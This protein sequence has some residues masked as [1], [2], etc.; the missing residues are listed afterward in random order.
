[1][2]TLDSLKGYLFRRRECFSSGC[3]SI[4]IVD[5]VLKFFLALEGI[6][7]PVEQGQMIII[8]KTDSYILP[9]DLIAD[10]AVVEI[11]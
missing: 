6:Y 3:I 10:R 1:M 4:R 8:F 2:R 9:S 11:I 5:K 7:L